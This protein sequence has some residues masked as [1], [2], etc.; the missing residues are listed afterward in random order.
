MAITI[1]CVTH[2]NLTQR[3]CA[4]L[5]IIVCPPRRKLAPY[6]RQVAPFIR[7]DTRIF[8]SFRSFH[9]F[10]VGWHAHSLERAGNWKVEE[11]EMGMQIGGKKAVSLSGNSKASRD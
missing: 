1:N 2:D 11:F 9:C 4:H 10:G 3:E 6:Y 8:D 7:R 5:T